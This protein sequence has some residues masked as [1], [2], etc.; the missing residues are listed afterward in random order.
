MTIDRL[1]P[2]DPVSKI[3]KTTETKKAIRKEKPDSV[4]VSG[5]AQKMSAIYKAT[6]TVKASP[7]LRM[8]RIAA[9]QKKLQSPDYINEKVL[10]SV[11]ENIM[12]TF[13]I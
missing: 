11:A 1:G 8:D 13:G 7:D 9:V 2:V 3:N 4:N 5:E 6:E 10:N 12:E